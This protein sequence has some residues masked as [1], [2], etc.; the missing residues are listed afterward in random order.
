LLRQKYS[1]NLH[2][3][4]KFDVTHTYKTRD[5]AV[6]IATVHRLDDGVPV[7]LGQVFVILHVVQ[8]GYGAHPASCLMGTGGKV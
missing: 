5:I 3:S 1:S 8:T 7:P 2:V 6:G 4:S